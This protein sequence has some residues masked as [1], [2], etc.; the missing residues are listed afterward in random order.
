M[1]AFFLYEKE[2]MGLFSVVELRNFDPAIQGVDVRHSRNAGLIQ[3]WHFDSKFDCSHVETEAIGARKQFG[4]DFSYAGTMLGSLN[5]SVDKKQGGILME[6]Y[7]R[8]NG[9]HQGR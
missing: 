2:G 7:E 8:G 4:V 9:L 5:R 3:W 6:S 1:A